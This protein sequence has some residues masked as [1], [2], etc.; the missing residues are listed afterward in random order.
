VSAA[1]TPSSS[2][3]YPEALRDLTPPP[4]AL[5]SLGDLETLN[6]RVVVAI[7]GT[8]RATS[9]GLR[10]T[11]ELSTALARAGA[12]VV[13]GMARGIDGAAHRG[14]LDASGRTVAVLGT[15]VDVIYPRAHRAM[16]QE[17]V[18][19]G[20][21][22]SD[23]PPGTPPRRWHFAE[24]NRIIAALAR[25]VF[26]VEAPHKSGALRTVD[27]ADRLNRTIAAIPG[28]IDSPQSAGSN[29]LLRDGAQFIASIDD[30]LTLAGLPPSPRGA[31][32][33]ENEV[34]RRIWDALGA[35][36]ASLDELCARSGLPVAECMSAV[37]GLELRGVIE[38]AL[39]GEIRRRI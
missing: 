32:D 29:E 35:G 18:R 34:E 39:T 20:L 13:S 22:L 27:F 24:R 5:W 2:P 17:I 14:A 12:C 3:E 10:V 28:P 23:M 33:V 16:Y 1:T 19:R 26:V 25:V 38:C 21:V 31:I 9:Y 37:T 8:R 7:V 11:R 36:G 30:A 15:P 6:A 4:D